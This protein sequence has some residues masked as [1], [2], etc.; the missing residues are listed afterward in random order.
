[1]C[2]EYSQKSEELGSLL[3]VN[4]YYPKDLKDTTTNK[5]VYK[6]TESMTNKK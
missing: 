3:S 2:A 4:I 1:M 5:W 6:D